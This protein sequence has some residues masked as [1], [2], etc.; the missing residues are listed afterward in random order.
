MQAMTDKRSSPANFA[1]EMLA[2]FGEAY[3]F[4]VEL[5]ERDNGRE[6]PIVMDDRKDTAIAH[7][8]GL[9]VVTHNVSD[10]EGTGVEMINPFEPISPAVRSFFVP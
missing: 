2:L 5:P 7:E 9:T 6:L 8:H 4:D 10:F 1:D 3:G